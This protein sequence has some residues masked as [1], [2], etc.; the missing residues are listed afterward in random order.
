MMFKLLAATTLG[1]LPLVS[2]HGYLREVGIDGEVY[3]ANIPRVTNFASPIRAVDDIVP[4]K[5]AANKSLSCGLNAQNGA[6]VVPAK[7]GSALTFDWAGGDNGLWPHNIGPMFT[8]LAACTGTTCDKFDASEAK[9]FKIDQTGR[10]SNGSW[11]QQFIMYGDTYT[12]QFP[13]NLAPGDYLVRHEIIALQLAPTVGG[14]EF[15]PS[16]T[17]IR[18][19]GSGTG[20]PSST[21]SFPGAYSDTDP[22]ILVPNVFT[23]GANYT[24]FP[25]PAI[26]PSLASSSVAITGHAPSTTGLPNPTS[27][28]AVFKAVETIKARSFGQRP[29]QISRVMLR[30]L[31]QLS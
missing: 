18:V 12:T 1:L 28:S 6:M 25:G 19:S 22:G 21:V 24:S 31:D 3:R 17:Q 27:V 11:F 16:C 30:H 15:Y 26:D 7:P 29:Q 9:W 2:A 13:Q 23:P 8:Y 4:V 10:Q 20:T 5:G 14:A